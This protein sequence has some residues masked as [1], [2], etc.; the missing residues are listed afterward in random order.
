MARILRKIE[1][2]EISAV[3]KPAQKGAKAVI[4]KR[5]TDYTPDEVVD[6][7]QKSVSAGETEHVQKHEYIEMINE[8]AEA[9][10]VAGETKEQ[11]FTKAI[12]TDAPSRLLY[13]LL[14]AAPGSEVPPRDAS[15]DDVKP[16]K[17][18][19]IGPAHAKLHSLAV[20]HRRAHPRLSYEAAYSQVYTAPQNTKLRDAAR[21]EHLSASLARANG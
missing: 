2:A 11:A 18:E 5:H 9:L 3:D 21:K 15:R 17:P 19:E 6:I 12:T 1:I 8:R 7:I 4:M 16:T 20:D 10:R 14:K 13:K